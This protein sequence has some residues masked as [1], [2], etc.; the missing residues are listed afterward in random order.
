MKGICLK[1]DTGDR[2][3]EEDSFNYF[4]GDGFIIV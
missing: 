1:A 2:N 3:D 4:N